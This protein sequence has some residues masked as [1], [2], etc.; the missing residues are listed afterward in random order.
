MGERVGIVRLRRAALGL[1]Y[2][3]RN[4]IEAVE[5]LGLKAKAGP[6]DKRTW[7][8]YHDAI[9][10]AEAGMLAVAERIAREAGGDG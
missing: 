7:R 8:Q 9:K 10:N 4:V 3:A 6:T 5:W 2:S 1:E